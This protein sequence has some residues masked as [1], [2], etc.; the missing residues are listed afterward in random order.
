M[1]TCRLIQ[2]PRPSSTSLLAASF[3]HTGDLPLP[4]A[5]PRSSSATLLLVH[6]LTVIPPPDHILVLLISSRSSPVRR[7]SVLRPTASR[8]VARAS[9]PRRWMPRAAPPP[10][11]PPLTA[12]RVLL[13]LLL[14]LLVLGASISC[15][16]LVVVLLGASSCCLVARRG[17][18][19]LRW[20]R[21]CV[22]QRLTPHED[23]NRA[24]AK[25]GTTHKVTEQGAC[26][27]RVLLLFPADETPPRSDR[28]ARAAADRSRLGVAPFAS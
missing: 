25:T 21:G 7:A 19:R 2:P 12:A 1:I 6:P 9:C 11:L 26:A 13:S 16:L 20:R 18:S 24:V 10:L 15:L 3:A 27:C 8:H 14:L 4:P 23:M 22:V 5:P 17:R 28:P